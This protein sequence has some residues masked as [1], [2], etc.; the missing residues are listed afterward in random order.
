MALRPL[1][2]AVLLL[3]ACDHTSSDK[4]PRMPTALPPCDFDGVRPLM[5]KAEVRKLADAR[6]WQ[7]SFVDVPVEI[8][9]VTVFPEKSEL[10]KLELTFD[11]DVLVCIEAAYAK[12]DPARAAIRAR[13]PLAVERDGVWAM[14]DLDQTVLRTV[15][16][17]GSIAVCLVP[18]EMGYKSLVADTQQMFR[19]YWPK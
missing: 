18:G 4:R 6:G 13:Y 16:A 17:D 8:E 15:A 2:L 7:H 14:T 5:T 19:Y 12:A 10:D 11:G 9:R 1:A 3:A